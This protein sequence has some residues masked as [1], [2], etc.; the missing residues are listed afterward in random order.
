MI[1]NGDYESL[2]GNETGHTLRVDSFS[3]K[4]GE[5]DVVDNL[6]ITAFQNQILV[7]IG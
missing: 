5:V 3:K 1:E 4:I 6:S 2:T 7:L